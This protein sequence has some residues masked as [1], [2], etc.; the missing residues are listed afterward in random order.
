MIH[1]EKTKQLKVVV[2]MCTYNGAH[3]I[4]EQLESIFQ[5]T[6]PVDEVLIADDGSTD[7]T[8]EIIKRF[9]QEKELSGWHI[10]VNQHNL[11]W[12]RN[13][14]SL[15]KRAEGDVFLFSD[16]DDFWALERVDKTL[17]LFD[18]HP[19]IE[20]LVCRWLQVDDEGKALPSH[21]SNYTGRLWQA[22]VYFDI[23]SGER[24]S[25]CLMAYRD[26]LN[27]LVLQGVQFA[28]SE[29]FPAHDVVVSRYAFFAGG[30]YFIDEAWHNHRFHGGNASVSFEEAEGVKGGW[31]LAGRL[32]YCEEELQALSSLCALWRPKGIDCNA[33]ER[34][35]DW[36]AARAEFLKHGHLRDLWRALGG[37]RW[38]KRALV[39]VIGDCCYRW[40]VEK[41]AGKFSRAWLLFRRC[42]GR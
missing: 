4:N 37:C 18:A 5:Q 15:M 16:Q 6:R 2:L 11:G 29:A 3:Y 12:K 7:N 23:N 33:V 41:A 27:Q 42:L 38:H 30:L 40:H 17:A 14:F 39:Q 26:G 13:F 35:S 8:V 24:Q 32:A 20:C 19:D 34:A 21:A 31:S 22:D 36:N 1:A 25:G 28:D 9:I 10:F